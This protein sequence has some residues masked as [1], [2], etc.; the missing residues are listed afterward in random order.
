[1]LPKRLRSI[2][3]PLF[4]LF[5][6]FIGSLL[7]LNSLI[8]RPSVQHYLLG[9]V[10][11]VVG[12]EIDAGPIEFSFWEGIGISARDFEIKLPEGYNKIAAA[13]IM[14]KLDLRELIRGNI[15]PTGLTLIEPKIEFALKEG[16]DISKPGEDGFFE[17][18]PLKA[19]A[20][21]PSVTLKGAQISVKEMPLK[22]TGLFL[23]LSR[24]S[25]DPVT[26][27]V[28][29]DGK[30]DYREEA[31]PFSAR[32]SITQDERG[33]ASAEV[34]LRASEIP[35]SRISWPESLPVKQG[36]AGIE[37]TANGALDG[38]FWAKGNITIK[39][40]EFMIID[41]GD[42][43]S[44]AFDEVDLPF[45]TF[46]SESKLYIPSFQMKAADFTLNAN[47]TL[48]L[49]DKSNP[50]LEIN[51]K[52]PAMSLKTFKELFPS[53][54]LPQWVESDLFPIFSG[55]DV[56][57]D[58]FSL[59]GTLNQIRNLDRPKNAGSLLLQLTCN[60]LTA[61]KDDGGVPVDGVSGNLEIEKGAIRVSNVEA[62]FRD[63]EISDGT[64][65]L[66]SLYVDVP[67][68]RVTVDGAFD[69]ADLVLQRGLSLVPDDVRQQLEGFKSV[70][71]KMNASVEIGHEAKWDYPKILK[72]R[73]KFRNC[74][75]RNKDLVFPVLLEEAGLTIDEE[76]RKLFIAEGKWG[77]SKILSSGVIGASWKTGE[78]HILLKA[79]MDELAGHF[80]PDL[81]SSMRFK[82]QVPSLISLSKKG[83][84]WAFRGTFDLKKTSLETESMTIDPF[85]E[86]G[87]VLFNGRLQP[88][89]K[90]YLTNLKCNLGESSFELA[91]S[92]DLR[93]KDLFDFRVS[94][95]KILLEDLGVRFKKGNL[96]GS[97]ALKFDATVK[98]SR[99]NPM[100]TDVT[101]WARSRDLFFSASA[102]YLP[103][104]DCN[105][106]LK[107][108][109][110]DL[111]IDFLN[112]KLG[113][114]PFHAKGELRGWDGMRGALTIK[115]D[116]LDLSDLISPEFFNNFNPAA[117][118]TD[119]PAFSGPNEDRTQAG[120]REGASR[121]M[122]KSDIHLDIT[123]PNGQWEGFRY[124]PLR[125]E[126]ALRSGD[127]YISRSSVE[128]E[129][130]K[131]LLRGHV[132]RGK[133]REMLFSS[134]IDL[135]KQPLK[136][137]PQS[138]EFVKSRAEGMLTIEALLFA[139]GSNK[140]DLISS[141]TGSINVM[142]EEGVLKKSHAFIKVM[143]F[144]SLRGIFVKRPPG[145]SK[146]GLY[147]E[148]IGGNIDLVEGVAKTEDITMQSPVF[149]AVVRGEA[150]LCTDKVNAEL[151]IQPLVTVDSLV[152]KLPIVG[153]LLT[154]DNEALYV[155]YFKVEGTLSDPDV[156]YI[157]LKSLGNTT[158]GFFKRLFLSPQRLFKSISDAARDFEGRGLPLPDE[159]FKPEN[160][161]GG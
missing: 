129:H 26:L 84:E 21:I 64:L 156:R 121:F 2:L 81:N 52:S 67:T 130:G 27:D 136:E 141:L 131:L 38:T 40:L 97:G 53:S 29:L 54:L 47:S 112:L 49:K 46:Y 90:F 1:M 55:G 34:S 8:Q 125:I 18:M 23:H 31:I 127:L 70:T 161:M 134:Y 9:Q 75:V 126:C 15:L 147:F 144:L 20:G 94:S 111:S 86:E 43:K 120:W 159:E 158:V 101:G 51:V 143:D 123:A 91:G 78:A 99:S 50:H 10:S 16:W 92:Y 119:S 58:L 62:H 22:V 154:G 19:L 44:F 146:G 5:L 155:D 37:M 114:S 24:K 128:A 152:S 36:I 122:K 133:S 139:K 100:M 12:Y 63:S 110:K 61:F 85:G 42:K 69:L 105:F 71:G 30:I 124:G 14:F 151:G 28:T 66:S 4:L 74:A 82:N 25:T 39:D 87:M 113:K 35:L 149:N 88:G 56:R 3:V 41:D 89:E 132:K 13:R 117:S 160:D 6:F 17:A 142:I 116:Y 93:G 68:I 60:G 45:H 80:F 103:V 96:R 72:G 79:D 138:L 137:L 11:K 145:L 65:Y 83:G 102:F 150:N 77:K 98:A 148:S 135:T 48:D 33:G 7:L 115:S 32:G 108:Q 140:E 104:E 57:V 106:G 153:Y 109:G 76:E 73:F 107:F 59:K 95:K 157:P 118:G